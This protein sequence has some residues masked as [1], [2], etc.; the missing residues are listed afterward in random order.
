MR[1]ALVEEDFAPAGRGTMSA[2]LAR[3]L[4]ELA[5]DLAVFGHVVEHVRMS[6]P[7][8]RSL[9][10]AE[11]GPRDTTS[12]GGV[13]SIAAAPG[14]EL[15]VLRAF[16]P[17][18]VLAV[19]VGAGRRLDD[20]MPALRAR[21]VWSPG[22]DL[23]LDD[24]GRPWWTPETAARVL[25]ATRAELDA[26]VR[27]GVPRSLCDVV[28]W[29]LAAR[30][31]VWRSASDQPRVVRTV[32][33]AAGPGGDGVADVVR[34]LAVHQGLRLVVAVDSSR[35]GGEDAL[36]PW[37]PLARGLGVTERVR[38]VPVSS[39]EELRAVL[40]R[41]GLLVSVPREEAQTGLLAAAMACGLP[42]VASDVDDVRN[43]VES[44]CSGLV[45][46]PA[47]GRRLA[48]TLAVVCRDASC[49]TQW[50]RAARRRSLDLFS[51][52]VTAQAVAEALATPAPGARIGHR[53][54]RHG[55]TGEA[56]GAVA[57]G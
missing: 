47:D 28:P 18:A 4:E 31:P 43:I 42:V 41:A 33:T 21:W 23:R 34:V 53:E 24:A 1:I 37:L 44:G 20:L 5:E 29:N 27:A 14:R 54:P 15:S 10:D 11:H 12:S 2:L 8:V 30:V 25:V 50:A 49:R 7:A 52:S 3:P 48:R 38:V 40:L 32:L 56:L 46:P 9:T 22:A 39:P 13:R 26:F 17:D 51:P 45:L 57:T 6:H 16:E 35:A 55:R 36:N 19:G